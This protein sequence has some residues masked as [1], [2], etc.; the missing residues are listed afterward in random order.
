MKSSQSLKILILL[1]VVTLAGSV[2][3]ADTTKAN[4][5]I[6]A[7]AQVGNT[8]LPAGDY[9]AKWSGSGPTVQVSIVRNGKTLATVPAK[10]VPLEQKSAVDS[11][12]V[13]NGAGGRRDLTALRFSGKKYSLEL[14][15]GNEAMRS[16]SVK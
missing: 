12:E 10:L 4:F 9:T 7:P 1:L 3:A 16:D 2:F 8:T 14:S 11:A 13:Q 5:Q 6:S 15:G